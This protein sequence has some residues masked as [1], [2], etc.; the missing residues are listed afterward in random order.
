M[1]ALNSPDDVGESSDR[2]GLGATPCSRKKF[3]D[4]GT[5]G[6]GAHET[7]GQ[8]VDRENCLS[9]ATRQNAV[10]GRMTRRAPFPSSENDKVHT[11]EP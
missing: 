2:G 9:N 10:G 11:S 5:P 4:T 8:A 6:K 7:V 1:R 3:G